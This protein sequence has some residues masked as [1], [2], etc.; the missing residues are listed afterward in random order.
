MCGLFITPSFLYH[1][2]KQKSVYFLDCTITIV[3]A[4][5]IQNK[6]LLQQEF[7]CEFQTQN[8]SS[9]RWRLACPRQLGPIRRRTHRRQRTCCLVTAPPPLMCHHLSTQ[10]GRRGN[11]DVRPPLS[12]S[13]S[14]PLL[15][16]LGIHM[17]R[18]PHYHLLGPQ[19]ICLSPL[20]SL[21]TKCLHNRL[22]LPLTSTRRAP[23]EE[24]P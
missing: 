2:A 13:L 12:P 3:G 4:K 11:L 17:P 10:H 8:G 9:G 23:L 5:Y 1:Y 16:Y 6:H 18:S 14:P 22:S 15:K 21:A 24:Y 7:T 20:A 19:P